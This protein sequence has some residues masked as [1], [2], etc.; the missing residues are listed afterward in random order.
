MSIIGKINQVGLEDPDFKKIV[1]LD[2][3][4]FPMPW[5]NESWNELKMEEHILFSWKKDGQVIGYCLFF[6]PKIEETAHLLK[7]FINQSYRGSPETSHFWISII[8]VL[9]KRAFKFIY[10]EVEEKNDRA[11]GFYRKVGFASLHTIKGF[12]S[13]GENAVTMQLEL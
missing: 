11:Q 8:N 10:L 2:Q 5:S 4:F 7:I 6:A 1:E 9:T 12:Y 3:N 13:N